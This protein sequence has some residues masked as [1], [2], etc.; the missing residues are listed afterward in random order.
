[1]PKRVSKNNCM[2]EKEKPDKINLKSILEQD[3]SID[4]QILNAKKLYYNNKLTSLNINVLKTLQSNYEPI[5]ELFKIFD[6]KEKFNGYM[7][8]LKQ[9]EINKNIEFFTKLCEDDCYA[10]AKPMISQLVNVIVEVKPSTFLGG[11]TYFYEI[12]LRFNNFEF[13]LRYEVC[14]KIIEHE[15]INFHDNGCS[16]KEE[17]EEVMDYFSL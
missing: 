12:C 11:K 7:E 5:L 8:Y 3:K 10:F 6:S 13:V 17:L 2:S 16:F 15:S 4:L 1:M 14:D 9:I